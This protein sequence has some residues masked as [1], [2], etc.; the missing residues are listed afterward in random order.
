MLKVNNL[1]KF[2]NKNKPNEIHVINDSTF[3]L[4]DKGL[5]SILGHSGSGKTTLLN[6]LCGI[7]KVDNG[8]LIIDDKVIK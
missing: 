1:N 7:D 4:G 5:V 6:S 8:E 3:E 2:Y